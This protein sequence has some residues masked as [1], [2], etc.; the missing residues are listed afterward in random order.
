MQQ[1]VSVDMYFAFCYRMLL[2]GANSLPTVDLPIAHKALWPGPMIQSVR[3]TSLQVA[4]FSTCGV[5][6]N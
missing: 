3:M 1:T 4:Q 2:Y 6:C 5:E